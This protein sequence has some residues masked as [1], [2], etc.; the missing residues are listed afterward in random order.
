MED[1]PIPGF[2]R[3]AGRLRT[4]PAE[5]AALAILLVGTLVVAVLWWNTAARPAVPVNEAAGVG[6][7]VRADGSMDGPGPGGEVTAADGSGVAGVAPIPGGSDVHDHG[8]GG[9]PAAGSV[10]APGDGP[11]EVVVHITGAVGA[12]GV[13]SLP[14]GSR[15]A[16]A[17]VAAGGLTPFAAPERINLARTLV[18]GEHVHVLRDGEDPPIPI[19][20][21]TGDADTSAAASGGVAPDGR[22]DLNRASAAE[23]ETLPSV[24]PARSAAIIEHR[25]THGP[26]QVPGDLRAVPGIGEV[27]FQRLAELVTAG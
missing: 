22:I 18:D 25:E 9:V 24:G 11:A 17:V 13:V 10:P 14:A 26:F 15:V 5:L 4:A 21:S 20:P 27:T 23:L 6:A 12:P 2:A 16:D 19:G 1:E 7:E 3:V 8:G